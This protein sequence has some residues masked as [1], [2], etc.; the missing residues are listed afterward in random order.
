M[1][2]PTFSVPFKSGIGSRLR[3]ERERLGL[4]QGAVARSLDISRRTVIN[5]ETESN[6]V[7]LDYIE[8][9]GQLGADRYYLL[10]G[11]RELEPLPRIVPAALKEAMEWAE[12][13]CRDSD[14]NPAPAEQTARFIA[15]V[16]EHLVTRGA[17]KVSQRELEAVL[18]DLARRSA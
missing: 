9:L 11:K 2:R 5:Y 3:E 13:F 18:I 7:L 1:S 6:P 17:Q 10:F 4:T 12:E 8:Q 14:G 16:Y 15:T